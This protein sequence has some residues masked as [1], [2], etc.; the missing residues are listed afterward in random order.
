MKKAS[1]LSLLIPILF[2]VLTICGCSSTTLTVSLT[3]SPSSVVVGK[4]ATI[5]CSASVT[6]GSSSSSVSSENFTYSWSA[7]GGTFSSTSSN[8]VTWTAPSTPGTYQITVRASNRSVSGSNSLNIIVVSSTQESDQSPV[9]TSL[10]ATPATG[11]PGFS[12]TLTCI[13]AGS[14]SSSTET[15][16]S[17][18]IT[19]TADGGTL[20]SNTGKTV[21][22]T[23]PT[24]EGTYTVTVSVSNGTYVTIGTLKLI[25]SSSSSS[26]VIK[27]TSLSYTPT[28]LYGGDVATLTCSATDSSN[29]ELTYSWAATSGTLATTTGSSTTWTSPTTEGTYQVISN[30]SDT[31]GNTASE[32]LSIVVK[33]KVD[34]P[35][36]NSITASSSTVTIGNQITLTCSATD[37]NN[38]TLTYAWSGEGS[39]SEATKA[40]TT[41]TAPDTTG[42]RQ[43]TITVSNGTLTTTGNIFISVTN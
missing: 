11:V 38:L 19:W 17:L 10:T 40:Q 28:T 22:W 33:K 6:S 15:T 2:F 32:I 1:K 27:I 35:V 3:A 7:N 25:V 16:T 5:S 14:S 36:I 9:I 31:A 34:P 41:W 30:V 29:L 39:F 13:T 18:S 20:S 43:L 21:S 24:T 42:S 12:S 8:P 4:T 23:A 37:P 26:S